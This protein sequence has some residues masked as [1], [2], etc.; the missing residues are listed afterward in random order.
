MQ[1]SL[2]LAAMIAILVGVA[3]SVLGEKFVFSQLRQQSWVPS[4]PAGPLH[5]SHVRIVW[6]S[7]HALTVFGF[8]LAAILLRLASP[9]EVVQL[10]AFIQNAVFVGMVAAALLVLVGTKARHPG[11]LG[12]LLVGLLT[13]LA[14]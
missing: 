7:W 11:W 4:K 9:V 2:V 12:L 5:E 1:L 10:S 6:A 3:H 8:V 13:W 14:R